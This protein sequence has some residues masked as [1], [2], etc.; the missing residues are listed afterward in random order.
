MSQETL[1]LKLAQYYLEQRKAEAMTSVR[2][3]FLKWSLLYFALLFFFVA[4]IGGC[5]SGYVWLEPYVGSL[6]ASILITI[7]VA[8][9]GMLCVLAARLM[10][11]PQPSSR[12]KPD[13]SELCTQ[14]CKEINVDDIITKHGL[15]IV[16][17]MF[18]IGFF[19]TKCRNK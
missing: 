14:L 1:I 8:I 9:L 17:A 5:L 13:I 3:T 18:V 16:A 6:K 7:A 12:T 10:K 11:R 2:R 15:K 19:S 4:F